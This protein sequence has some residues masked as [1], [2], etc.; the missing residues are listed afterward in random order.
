MSL[1]TFQLLIDSGLVV[2][3]WMVQLIVYPSFTYMTP[4]DLIRWHTEYTPRITRIVAPLMLGQLAFSGLNLYSSVDIYSV[5]YAVLVV[6]MWLI[7]FLFFIPLH[8]KIQEGLATKE[9]LD[10]L[11]RINWARTIVWTTLLV[12]SLIRYI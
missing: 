3:I 1:V 2:L 8:G 12:L 10:R 9:I 7:T 4:R 11:I 6:L 5:S